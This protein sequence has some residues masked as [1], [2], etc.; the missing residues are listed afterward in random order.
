MNNIYIIWF[1]KWNGMNLSLSHYIYIHILS[2]II[3]IV[4]YEFN[5]IINNLL[6]L[7]SI[8]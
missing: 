8:A 7:N 1:W 2:L 3:R 4:Y 6:Y 5:S